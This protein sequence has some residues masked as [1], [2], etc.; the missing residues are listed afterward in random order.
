MIKTG[1]EQVLADFPRE[2]AR[3]R[4]GVLC[5]AASVTRRYTHIIDELL[6]AGK[7][8]IGAIF[9]PQHG[10]CGETQDNMIEWEGFLHPRYN[11]PVFSLYGKFRKPLR[12]MIE[13]LDALVVDLQD[14]GARPYTY[15]W[16]VKLC[17]EACAEQGIAVWILDRPNPIAAVGFDGPVLD[18]RL[19]S[20]VGGAPIPLCHRMTMGEM[21]TLLK[22]LYFPKVDLHVVWMKGWGRSMLWPH[23]GLP[24]VLPSPNMPAFETAMVYPGMVLL[25][26]TNLSE[27]RGTT[28]PFELFGAPYINTTELMAMFSSFKLPGVILREHSYIPTFQKWQGQRCAGIYIHVTEPQNYLPVTTTLEILS[29]VVHTSKGAFQLKEPPYEYETVKKPFDILAGNDRISADLLEG[30]SISSISAGFE[31]ELADF[32][33]RFGEIAHYPEVLK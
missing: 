8:R 24:W 19:H 23:T 6:S 20:F 11:V 4:V 13:G 25:E 30:K 12:H 22:Q 9:G 21:A 16:T 5:H 1:L 33:A 10:L 26:A 15:I 29:A 27:G 18:E 28:R 17:M 3:T 32:S 31:N 7:C 2:L 14:V